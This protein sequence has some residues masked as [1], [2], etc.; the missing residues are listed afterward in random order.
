MAKK[1]SGAKSA[2]ESRSDTSKSLNRSLSAAKKANAIALKGNDE[3]PG[4]GNRSRV[5][6]PSDIFVDRSTLLGL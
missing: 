2:T 1:S 4:G 5:C 3:Y 6:D